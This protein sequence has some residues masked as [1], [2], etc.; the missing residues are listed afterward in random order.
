MISVERE[1]LRRQD[2]L[3]DQSIVCFSI[4]LG[5]DTDVLAGKPFD[6]AVTWSLFAI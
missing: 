5:A 6:T 4:D 1:I 3:D 2:R